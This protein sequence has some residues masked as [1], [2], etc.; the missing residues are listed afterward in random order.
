MDSTILIVDDKPDTVQLLTAWLQDEGY[1]TLAV[2][3]GQEALIVAAEHR[4]DLI[5]MDVTMPVLDGIQACRQ[6]RANPSTANIPVILVTAKNPTDARAEGLL[7]GAV[8]YVTKPIDLHDLSERVAAAL[9]S[10]DNYPVDTVRL[11]D[12]LAHSALAILSCDLVWLFR[13]NVPD[14]ALESC[15][16]A[17]SRGREGLAQFAVSLGADL[18]TFH[19]SLVE[20]DNFLAEA[21][22]AQQAV[23]DV[24][25]DRLTMM[26]GDRPLHES[27][28]ALDLRS[29]SLVPLA[30][31]SR[32]IGLLVIGTAEVSRFDSPRGR[33]LIAALGSQASIAL[34]YTQL[35]QNLIE[36]EE[37][38]E[39]EH[40]FLTMILDAMGDALVV[41]GEAGEIE[42][43][44]SRLL[45]MTDYTQV[46]LQG[47]R[48]DMLF[49]P[50]DRQELIRSLLRGRGSTM[51]FDQRLYTKSEK[52]IPVLLSRTSFARIDPDAAQQ[53]LVLSDLTLQKSREDA[54]E[55]Q[56]QQLRALN[57]AAEAIS[58]S[59]SPHEVIREILNAAVDM[60][61]AE[62]ASVL[63][64]SSEAPD[65]LVF[66]ATAGE[67]SSVIQGVR[68]PIGEGVAGWV[69]REATSQLVEDTSRDERFYHKIDDLTGMSTRS[70]IA[71]PLIVTDRVI[72]VLEAINKRVGTFDRMDMDLLESIAGT[73]AVAIENARLFEQT[74]RRL[75]DLG[76]LLDASAAV[77]S[78]LDLG[79][80]LEL[81][82][83]R[84]LNALQVDR[85]LIASW[86][87]AANML[88]S[89]AEVADAYWPVGQGPVCANKQLP[90][91]NGVLN[92]GLPALLHVDDPHCDP[93]ER[94]HLLQ[95]GQRAV[96]SV[97]LWVAGRVEGLL[98]VYS[99]LS[100]H[101]FTDADAEQVDRI[102]RQWVAALDLATEHWTDRRPLTDLCSE[103]QL[104]PGV[105]WV[106]VEAWLPDRDQTQRLREYGFSLWIGTETGFEQNP[107]EFPTMARALTIAQPK[108]VQ[109]ALLNNDPRERAY[110][111]Q[112]G[113]QVCLLVPFMS[114][115]Q[116]EGL[117]KLIDSDAE[118]TFDAEQISLGQG[119]ANVV[120][121][122]MEN[123]HLYQNL[124]RRAE[125]LEAAYAALKQ[126]DQ[127]KDDLLQNLSHEIQTPL[128][129]ILGYSELMYNEAFGPLT[130]EQ[131]ERLAFIV[132]RAQHLSD[133]SKNIIAV[134]ALQMQSLDL[135]PTDLADVVESAIRVWTPEAAKRSIAFKVQLTRPVAPVMGDA[136]QLTEA[137]EH[138]LENAIKFSPN[139][140]AIEVAVRE[141][142]AVVEVCVR[143]H[144]VGIAPEHHEHIFKRFYQVD[145]SASRKYG[146]TGLGLA[147]THEIITQ[148][149]GR[150]WVESA[151]QQGSTFSFFIPRASTISPEDFHLMR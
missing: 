10:P 126:A 131:R 149:G 101:V 29:I 83:R 39:A 8:D 92:S 71:V 21:V 109:R 46:D 148:H 150:I 35:A 19:L 120:G 18:K 66:I 61:T 70:L 130:D 65:E 77:S 127:L 93:V 125:A 11:L 118:R 59:L 68:V 103:L 52:V 138:L 55:R 48:V 34:D 78:T 105:M 7:A 30:A 63:L 4:P 58:S 116:P 82:A 147:I 13:V 32:R 146:G 137:V 41:I 90:L 24:P 74:R 91:R 111:E 114:R 107:D 112:V 76:T 67:Q 86:D 110:L 64:R 44:N 72:G 49:H 123:A 84:L 53:V 26:A 97:P 42:Y 14:Q 15:A 57:Q 87:R 89:L 33:Q 102:V 16:A 54:L 40:T 115:G 139:R 45:L 99:S 113:G 144:G 5:L 124:E 141:R 25:T 121:N 43:V 128:L 85:C 6:L 98:L 69:A 1:Q 143:D 36:Q 56:S 129:H 51:K 50:D 60:V 37:M 134:Q 28:A 80:V 132:E 47:H 20:G 122:A 96:M 140:Q 117:I 104:I 73:A 75:N 22:W 62:G 17:C 119:I 9:R 81:I 100:G 27:F 136:R 135:H 3:D 31:G 2:S 23:L 94:E 151:P 12:E 88:H 142:E 79:S 145:S 38:M 95:A 106:S 133:L 108:V